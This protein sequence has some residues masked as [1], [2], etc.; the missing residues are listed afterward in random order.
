MTLLFAGLALW[1]L[2]HFFPS[3]A[4][5]SRRR[6]IGRLGNNPY[7]GLFSLA[8]VISLVLM[9]FGWR[10]AV[11][12]A[13]YL[14]PEWGRLA[15][16]PLMLAAFVLFFA[17]RIPGNLKRFIRH[18]QL[19][20]VATWAFAHLLTNGEDRSVLLFGVMLAWALTETVLISRREGVWQKPG[21]AAI[22]LDFINVVVGT[23]LFLLLMWLHPALFN[24][25]PM[26][27]L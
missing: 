12:E 23:V 4:V 10:Q 3:L 9:V 7:R 6:L 20:G 1:T 14:P 22:K 5:D 21:T 15:A 8:I 26:G 24:V 25:S 13:L 2:A 16:L 17:S 27:Q 11:P 19:T 18:P